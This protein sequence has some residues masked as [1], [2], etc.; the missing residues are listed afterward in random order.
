MPEGTSPRAISEARE[1]L[2]ERLT[3]RMESLRYENSK[4]HAANGF[5]IKENKRLRRLV[6]T[7]AAGLVLAVLA[8]AGVVAGWY[9]MCA[10]GGR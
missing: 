7:A 5:L 4:V 8:L 1:Q 3:E 2:R 10:G 6:W 9:Q